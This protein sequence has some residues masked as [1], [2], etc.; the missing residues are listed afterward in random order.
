[1]FYI[2]TGLLHLNSDSVGNYGTDPLL[3]PVY[4]LY[5]ESYRYA[6]VDLV[7]WPVTPRR[8]VILI[9]FRYLFHRIIGIMINSR[10]G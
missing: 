1:M 8:C 2:S 4:S 6:Q 9:G 7:V 3:V 10:V 5:N